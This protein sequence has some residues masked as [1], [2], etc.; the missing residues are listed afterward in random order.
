MK[1]RPDIDSD[2]AN[3]LNGKD[4]T[5]RRRSLLPMREF[6]VH[7]RADVLYRL[8]H[9]SI[10]AHVVR[11]LAAKMLSF[12]FFCR[13]TV[14]TA[15]RYANAVYDIALC[16]SVSVS[17]RLSLTSRYGTKTAKHYRI[18][19]ITSHNSS[20]TGVFCAEDIGEIP[21]RSPIQMR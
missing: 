1:F 11:K 3:A 18:T 20:W 8:R 15:Q 4:S 17:V 2:F 9:N 14:C 21:L 13:H 10:P 12:P 6:D 7:R 19:K 16:P 5:S